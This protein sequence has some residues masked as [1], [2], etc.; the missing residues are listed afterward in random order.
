MRIYSSNRDM[1][2][3]YNKKRIGPRLLYI[4]KTLAQLNPREYTDVEIIDFIS[5]CINQFESEGADFLITDPPTYNPLFAKYLI[6][7]R[8]NNCK[9]Y[10]GRNE[11]ILSNLRT[12]L[13]N[14]LNPKILDESSRFCKISD[15]NSMLRLPIQFSWGLNGNRPV[16]IFRW[17]EFDKRTKVVTNITVE[18]PDTQFCVM[19]NHF[20]P[21][22]ETAHK[23]MVGPN[24]SIVCRKL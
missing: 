17:M 24:N 5:T 20:W 18:K 7:A 15:E 6:S 2:V 13:I 8:S 22:D 12:A 4:G 10:M 3:V 11:L 14:Y 21:G 19:T 1:V 9:V 16:P 23:I